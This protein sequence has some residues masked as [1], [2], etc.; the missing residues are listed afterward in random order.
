[1]TENTSFQTSDMPLFRVLLADADQSIAKEMAGTL[2]PMPGSIEITRDGISLVERVLAGTIDL[3]VSDITLPLLSGLEAL[4]QLRQ[5]G[6]TVPFIVLSAHSEP[7]ITRE[8]LLSGCN[9][10]VIKQLAGEELCRAIDAVVRGYRYLSPRA[11]T[12]IMLAPPPTHRLSRRQA[13][14]INCVADGFRTLDI[15]SSLGIS[16][17]TVECH[18][19]ALLRLFGVHNSIALI[20]EA[21]KHGIVRQG[22]ARRMIEVSMGPALS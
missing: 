21:E 3:V 11:L 17:R 14:I 12:A 7:A 2:A 19:Q 9:G 4:Q 20:R 5:K 8:A 10:Y 1:M 13:Q 16:P 15:A 6:S 22:M 18:R